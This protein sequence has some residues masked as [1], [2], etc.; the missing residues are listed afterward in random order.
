MP[1]NADSSRDLDLILFGATGFTGG[2]TA[3]YL[4]EHGPVGLRWALAGRSLDKLEKVRADLDAIKPGSIDLELIVVDAADEAALAKSVA[5]TKV[6]ATTVGPYLELGG[7]LVAACAASG[8][9]YVDL[10]GEPEFVDRT[11]LEH[12]E[13][14]VASGAR[15]VHACGFDSIPHDLGAYFTVQQLKAAGP[16]TMR[17][18]VRSNGTFS[19]GTFHSAMGAFSRAKQMAATAKK[20]R[21]AEA[22]PEGRSSRAVAGKPGKDS[23]LG[24]WLVPLPT[25]DPQV[26]ARSGAALTAY[27]P[28]FRYSHFAGTKTLRYAVGGAVG[29]SLI[30]VASQ[31]K[32]ARNFL[33]G[34]V[35]QGQ[36]PDESKRAKSRFSV[37]FVAEG[38]GRT[39]HTRV[40]G[41]D[42]GY[43]ETSKMLAE[44]ALC[45]AF[46]DNPASAGSVTP[47]QS[48][49]DNLL[50]RLRAAG[51]KFEVVG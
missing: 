26:V 48:M 20:R 40:S 19:G 39:L 47:A 9:D 29:A 43:G 45:L 10:T 30:G 24:Y 31:V 28:E 44:A 16:V 13:T 36:G 22:R 18:V 51:M 41:G 7:P 23:V 15:I 25:I 21:Q 12:H 50:G 46:D 3:E 32:P 1:D 4:A 5:R 11:W 33:L 6:V 49:G 17:G 35:P 42:P 38:D 2:L 27:G 8:T 34:K 14:A 37:D